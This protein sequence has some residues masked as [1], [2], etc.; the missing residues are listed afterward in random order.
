MS[1]ISGS[2]KPAKVQYSYR[3]FKTGG[4]VTTLAPLSKTLS[5]L[6]DNGNGYS[7]TEL[8]NKAV[9]IKIDV[10][11]VV[12]LDSIQVFRINYIQNGQAPSIHKICERRIENDQETFTVI[13][14]G[15]NLEQL[16]LNE[17]LSYVSFYIKPKI[18]ESKGDTLFAANLKYAQDDA[19]KDFDGYDARSFSSGNYWNV[20]DSQNDQYSEEDVEFDLQDEAYE[21][22]GGSVI[23][24]ENADLCHRQFENSNIVYDEAYWHPYY[25]LLNTVNT[26]KI[27]GKGTNIDWELVKETVDINEDGTVTNAINTYK[28]DETYRFGIVLYNDKGKASSVKWIAD[29][30]IPPCPPATITSG[31]Y[32]MERCTIKFIIKHLPSK[33][34]GYQIVQCPRT[35]SDRHVLM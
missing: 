32:Q 14:N 27:G 8:S 28:H 21:S 26:N 18:I 20:Y 25:R 13:D 2:L 15:Q 34:T 31:G 19:D 1:S 29:I 22:T 33:C 3:L 16:G 9:K 12:D 7:Y 30:R 11:D 24:V 10:K 17:F 5:I 35:I 23:E 4:A 6:K